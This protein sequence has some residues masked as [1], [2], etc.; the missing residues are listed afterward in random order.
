MAKR[1]SKQNKQASRKPGEL[2]RLFHE[3][4]R[5]KSMAPATEHIYWAWVKRFI[6]YQDM[7][8]P[9]NLEAD[10][11]RDYLNH[12]A[13]KRNVAASTQ[14]QALN[15]LVFLFKRVLL[16]DLEA[17]GGFVRARKPKKLPVVMSRREATCVL[18][19]IE[20]TTG[21]VA[22]LMYGS[23]LRIGEAVQLRVKDLDF[24]YGMIHVCAGK[25]EKDRKTML[26]DEVVPYLRNHLIQVR[27]IH[28]NDLIEGGGQVPLPYAFNRKST[29]AATDWIWQWVFPS[30]RLSTD[31]ATGEIT[32]GHIAPSTIQRAVKQAAKECGLIKRVT[33]HTLRH[34][35]A[36]HLIE[37]GC[38]IRTVQE[39]LGH[40]D[41][42]TTM[43][44]THVLGRGLS[45][46]SPLD[47]SL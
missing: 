31:A 24:E 14:N 30:S 46:R 34:S 7:Q 20:G 6:R 25:G 39:L 41:L 17:F 35:F 18:G 2:Q 13:S 16:Q 9:A 3:A 47:R 15:A 29:H 4:C 44:Y 40:K 27:R 22:R 8:H 5:R 37:T 11:V 33:S 42:R 26:P 43:M 1:E 28:D 32:R 10:D 36:T 38:D 12:L 45:V 21:L 23:G 19:R